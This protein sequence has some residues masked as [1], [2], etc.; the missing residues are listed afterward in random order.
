MFSLLRCGSDKTATLQ[1]LQNLS[2]ENYCE[3]VNKKRY[4]DVLLHVATCLALHSAYGRSSKHESAQLVEEYRELYYFVDRLFAF[5]VNDEGHKRLDAHLFKVKFLWPRK[6]LEL[7]SYRV[8]DFYD[9]LKELKN[10]WERKCRGHFNTNKMTKQ[11][12]YR[13]MT[14]KERQTRQYTTLFYLGKGLG[15]DVF[16]HVNELTRG[17]GSVDWENSQTKERL[18]LLTGVVESKN[19]IRMQNPLESSRTIDVYYS[20]F[21][22]GVFSKEEVSFYLGF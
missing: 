18:K 3:P 2:L 6:E 12:V 15:L 10:R 21:C 17:Q 19:I 1:E 22:Q 13:N 8:Q 5:E 4:N 16:V 20:S 7:S 9:A 11:K 14:F